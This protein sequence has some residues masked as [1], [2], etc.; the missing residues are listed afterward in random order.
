[1]RLEAI[2][3]LLKKDLD[4]TETHITSILSTMSSTSFSKSVLEYV[5]SMKGKMLRPILV[6]LS[7]RLLFPD[8]RDDE[9]SKLLDVVSAVEIIHMASLVHDDVIDEAKF[10]RGKISLN[11]KYGNDVAVTMGVYLYSI[12]LKLIAR[13]ES[14]PCLS[15]LSDT[16]KEM[17]EGEFLQYVGRQSLTYSM[18]DYFSIIYSKTAVLFKSACI[19]GIRLFNGKDSDCEQLTQFALSLGE[20]YQLTDDYLDCFG[21]EKDLNKDVGQDIVQGQLTLPMIKVLESLDKKD[22][23]RVLEGIRQKD[24][25]CLSILK[26]KLHDSHIKDEVYGIISSKIDASKT[27]LSRLP[28]NK[29]NEALASL[30]DFVFSRISN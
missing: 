29:Y 14:V 8:L 23:A 2:Y 19:S 17:C 25:S 11:E 6:F 1:M 16:V 24:I 3:L 9:Y 7:T 15:E 13:T 21:S 30:A 26:E 20:A 27:A 10:R 12:S 22:Q 4:A 5:I 28:Q 18:D